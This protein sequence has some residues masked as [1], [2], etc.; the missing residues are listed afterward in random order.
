MFHK[1]V[2][3]LLNAWNQ[4][5]ISM[6]A[7]AINLCSKKY[8]YSSACLSFLPRELSAILTNHNSFRFYISAEELIKMYFMKYLC[9]FWVTGKFVFEF[10][11][12]IFLYLLEKKVNLLRKSFSKQFEITLWY[13]LSDEC[14]LCRI[15]LYT[16][17]ST[18]TFSMTL[19]FTIL[20]LN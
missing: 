8:G 17:M 10:L 3:S 2:S 5:R 9:M 15:G 1:L 19:D 14:T 7:F 18:S 11:K 16:P 20:L 13:W 12:L 4:M 6:F